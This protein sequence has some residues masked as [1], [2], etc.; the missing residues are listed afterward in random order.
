MGFSGGILDWML[1]WMLV[2]GGWWLVVGGWFIAYCS[3]LSLSPSLPPSLSPLSP[4]S[5]YLHPGLYLELTH[6]HVGETY[7][8]TWVKRILKIS[9][10]G[11]VAR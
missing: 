1:D 5:L 3:L 9:F 10:A 2:V 7:S 4:L 8:E 11:K 6:G